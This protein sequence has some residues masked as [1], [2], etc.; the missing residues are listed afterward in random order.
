MRC[1]KPILSGRNTIAAQKQPRPGS[2][3][4]KARALAAMVLLKGL[5]VLLKKYRFTGTTFNLGVA[6]FSPLV[7]IPQS[8]FDSA[9]MPGTRKPGGFSITGDYLN[10]SC[11]AF[12][13]AHFC[14]ILG[15]R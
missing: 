4:R 2:E 6:R 8:Y 3:V 15:L 11:G 13:L 7:T 5:L 14:H 10:Y 9:G 1:A 12:C